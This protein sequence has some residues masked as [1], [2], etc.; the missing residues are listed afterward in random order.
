MAN[1]ITVFDKGLLLLPERKIAFP[2]DPEFLERERKG[3]IEDLRCNTMAYSVLLSHAEDEDSEILHL[4]MDALVSPDN[5]YTSIIQTA[6]ASGLDEFRLPF[7]LTNCHN[8][9]SAIGG[10]INE[11]DHLFGYSCARRYGGIFV[12]AYTAVIHQFMRERIVS[13]GNLVMGSD[14]HT[15]Y[16][17]L[18]CLGI[19]EGG[20]ELVKQLVGSH[21]ELKRPEVV[22]VRL[23]GELPHG[24]GSHDL[25]LALSR[26]LFP[27]GTVRNKILEFV[28]EG[29][30][31][32]TMDFRLAI[33]AMS[34][35]CGALSSIW[36][37]DSRTESW[38]RDH[39]RG[40]A[41]KPMKPTLPAYYDLLVDVDLSQVHSMI[42]LPFHPSNAYTVTEFSENA[43]DIIG[44]LEKEA[45]KTMPSFSLS[46]QFHDGKFCMNQASVAG[47]VGGL[48]GNIAVLAS[49]FSRSK[50]LGS[51]QALHV[52]PA[53]MQIYNS[54]LSNGV[55]G[56]ISI[57]GI[58]LMQ[59]SCGPC[60]GVQDIPGNS[61]MV[62]RHITRNFLNR[63]GARSKEGQSAAVAIMDARS[64][65]ATLLNGGIVTSAEDLD[66]IEPDD[67]HYFDEN[68]Y[69]ERVYW[70]FG[71]PD[72]NVS[73]TKGPN[74]ADWPDFEPLLENLVLF[75]ISSYSG[76]V[77][78]DEL[79]PSGEASAYR[80]NPERLACFTLQNRDP[81]YYGKARHI[82]EFGKSFP[83]G[84]G[85]SC[86]QV[87]E[88][89]LRKILDD[90]HLE[91]KS[92]SIGSAIVAERIGE[93]SAREQSASS[94][95]ILGGRAD[96]A[97]EYSTKRFRSNLINWGI[98]PLQV[99]D[100]SQL[101]AGQILVL[102]GIRKIVANGG[103]NLTAKVFSESGVYSGEVGLSLPLASDDEARILLEGCLINTYKK[104][105]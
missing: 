73:V 59:S 31:N 92:T 2:G 49:I 16:G 62:M 18:G 14:S 47:C 91:I 27:N 22:L 10:T 80:S 100:H 37:S 41:Y 98:L 84:A 68:L 58:N 77:T 29:I 85:P 51:S 48:Y 72:C 67:S 36:E 104:E 86:D 105:K 34:T 19:G 17:A 44:Q 101:C 103:G 57:K 52:F 87:L 25:S 42:A 33:D 20:G 3:Q 74:I 56:G 79:V 7:V 76:S 90:E 63:E 96:I 102:E 4:S 71:K 43:S 88:E 65:G 38:Y 6:R 83:R 69:E 55:A 89:A 8:S 50:G 97:V 39:G 1:G 12:P 46:G 64:I 78:T 54:L 23:N 32:L 15:R 81:E 11:D 30:G 21:Y 45:R 82:R 70:G 9:L 5:A 99:R 61:T 94:Q 95:R 13:S 66:Y 26:E 75:V 53:S 35:E 40:E 60:F 28:G 24:V 93:G